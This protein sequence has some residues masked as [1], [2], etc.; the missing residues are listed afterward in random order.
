[1]KEHYA[2]AF[3]IEVCEDIDEPLDERIVD[4]AV[5][6]GERKRE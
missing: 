5:T 1:V 2:E 4:V 3:R 6:R